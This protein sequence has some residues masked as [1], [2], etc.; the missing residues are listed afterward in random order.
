MKSKQKKVL[1]KEMDEGKLREEKIYSFEISKG[2]KKG[3]FQSH[4][5]RVYIE[6]D[7]N[8][9]FILSDLLQF[10]C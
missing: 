8:R 9:Q 10:V 2:N 1:K 7:F 4:I 6:I 5:K 3:S